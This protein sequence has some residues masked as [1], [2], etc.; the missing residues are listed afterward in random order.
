[1]DGNGLCKRSTVINCGIV[2]NWLDILAHGLEMKR[3]AD[4]PVGCRA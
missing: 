1:M 3:T 2:Y 4:D